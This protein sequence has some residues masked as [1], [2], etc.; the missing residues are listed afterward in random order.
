MTDAAKLIAEIAAESAPPTDR[1]VFV[2][3]RP[4]P[5]CPC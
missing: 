5:A 1:A 4:S 2:G 3:V